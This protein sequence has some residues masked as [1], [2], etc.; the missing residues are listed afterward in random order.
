M[1]DDLKG[2]HI[3]Q[4]SIEAHLEDVVTTHE[5]SVLGG[6]RLREDLEHS[7]AAFLVLAF[8]EDE[9]LGSLLKGNRLILLS[10]HRVVLFRKLHVG[11]LEDDTISGSAFRLS[12][13]IFGILF[14]IFSLLIGF[15]A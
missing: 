6:G 1:I 8:L 12:I 13:A 14:N 2:G 5:D 4:V 11:Q 15:V 10:R 7:D 3:D 9:Q